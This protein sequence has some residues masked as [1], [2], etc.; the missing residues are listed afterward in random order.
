MLLPAVSFLPVDVRKRCKHAQGL[1]GL[2]K[3]RAWRA[4]GCVWGTDVY[5]DGV[6]KWHNLGHDETEARVRAHRLRADVMEGRRTLST[7]TR[8]RDVAEA[9]LAEKRADP[10][11]RPSSLKNWDIRKRYAVDFLG[12]IQ[13]VNLTQD[14]LL[15]LRDRIGEERTPGVAAN[16]VSFIQGVVTWHGMRGGK[17]P[18]LVFRGLASA[19][20]RVK[21]QLTI[22]ELAQVVAAMKEP[23]RGAAEVAL[24]TGLRRGEVLALHVEDVTPLGLRVHRNLDIEGRV[25]PP[26]TRSSVRIVSLSPRGRVIVDGRVRDVGDGR[27]WP[28]SLQSADRAVRRAMRDVGVHQPRLGWHCF[29]HGHTALLNESGVSI[30]DAAA[31]LGHGANY[32]QSLA[33]GWAAEQIDAGAVDEAVTRHVTPRPGGEVGQP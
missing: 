33:Y 21:P 25:G 20:R 2:R 12:D 6:R 11:A 26:K 15:R 19:P 24:L 22:P 1:S 4:C 31:R 28:F 7:G 16:V 10:E 29:R 9:W 32:A 8:F 13:L 18:P 23:L 3:L 5:L 30:R 17:V 27:L 14:H